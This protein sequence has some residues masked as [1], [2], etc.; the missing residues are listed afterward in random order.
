MSLLL[1]FAGIIVTAI[2]G[3]L[4]AYRAPDRRLARLDV[5]S[6]ILTRLDPTTPAATAVREVVNEHARQLH[7]DLHVRRDLKGSAVFFGIYFLLAVAG[8]VTIDR[9]DHLWIDLIGYAL[10]GFALACLVEGI[11]RGERR[12]R[13]RDGS[14]RD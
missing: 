1:P 5:E 11:R 3:A 10:L 6:Q 9:G 13:N 12:P 14:P 2:L 8:L 4:T 7:A